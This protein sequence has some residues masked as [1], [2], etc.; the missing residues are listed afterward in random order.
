M[1]EKCRQSSIIKARRDYKL[2]LDMD[3]QQRIRK[4]S[5]ISCTTTEMMFH[6][7]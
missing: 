2:T 6:R 4:P 3:S 7:L 1:K 5:A